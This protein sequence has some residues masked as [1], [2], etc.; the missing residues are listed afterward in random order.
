MKYLLLA[1][2]MITA[3]AIA[4]ERSEIDW[5]KL[6]LITAGYDDP[7]V[8][9]QNLKDHG[10]SDDGARTLIEYVAGGEETLMRLAKKQG[11]A[12]CERRA[13]LVEDP[14]KYAQD[15][16]RGS[17]A[18]DAARKGLVDGIGAV[19]SPTDGTKLNEMLRYMPDPDFFETDVV[20]LVR[21]GRLDLRDVLDR[22]CGKEQ[23]ESV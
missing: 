16:E 17:A 3:A 11:Q 19:L 7:A 15:L 4:T 5:I 18:Y 9:L 14:E 12:R 8:Q 10:I 6:H 13:E 2:L 21:S 20:A 1:A 22:E 23:A